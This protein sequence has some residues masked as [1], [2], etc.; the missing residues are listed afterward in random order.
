LLVYVQ[1]LNWQ[2]LELIGNH[3]PHNSLIWLHQL[4]YN[5]SDP[6]ASVTEGEAA[7]SLALYKPL[8]HSL[9]QIRL[10]QLLPGNKGDFIRCRLHPPRFLYEGGYEAL[11]YVWGNPMDEAKTILVDDTHLHITPNLEGALHCIRDRNNSRYLWIDAVCINQNDNHEKNHQVNL[12]SD[13]YSRAN[14][15]LVFL[16]SEDD[17]SEAFDYFDAVNKA[18]RNGTPLLSPKDVSKLLLVFWRLFTKPWW[19]RV[20]VI[21]EFV[22][23]S[24]DSLI[25]CGGR[26]TTTFAFIAGFVEL[27]KV[28]NLKNSLSVLDFQLQDVSLL[29]IMKM[30][31]SKYELLSGP[32]LRDRPELST[33]ITLSRF[34]DSTDQRDKIFALNSLM[35]EPFRTILDPDYSQSLRTVY[36]EITA[37]LLCIQRWGKFYKFFPVNADK[38][39]PSW[40]PD[41]SQHGSDTEAS[42]R[43]LQETPVSLT[44]G[45]DCWVLM[46]TLNIRGVEFD[47]IETTFEINEADVMNLPRIF[48]T[49]ESSMLQ[50]HQTEDH[51]TS[52]QDMVREL[53]RG[54]LLQLAAGGNM[55]IEEFLRRST[56]RSTC[57]LSLLSSL[58]KERPTSK[59][60][61][62]KLIDL[63]YGTDAD[64]EYQPE[65][66]ALAGDTAFQIQ[67]GEA[68]DQE[69][70]NYL[71]K[72]FSETTKVAMSQNELGEELYQLELLETN[73]RLKDENRQLKEQLRKYTGTEDHLQIEDY[74][75]R[76]APR[77]IKDFL[78][79]VLH[80]TV[81]ITKLGLLGMGDP[82]LKKGDK[83]TILFGIPMPMA[84]RCG[85]APF[86]HTMVGKARVNGIMNGE[87]MKFVDDGLLKEKIFHIR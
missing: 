34:H 9:P 80:C 50:E 45:I 85:S 41:Y 42:G 21:Q 13:I 23:A 47:T 73:R 64:E 87:L 14:R 16:G 29:S 1:L 57:C 72:N 55:I 20:W 75:L 86:Y 70:Q 10:L 78:S 61:P 11:S 82:G 2:I 22:L 68:Q 81:F 56:K 15:V 18:G 38:R 7:A 19:S 6:D 62:A 63:L 5:S 67:L 43:F 4:I 12:M 52:L 66:D 40:V 84:L 33:L 60:D 36:T 77:W 30:M 76:K 48:Y 44:R 27:Q 49:I 74:L 31:D 65:L 51:E 58:G 17:C 35:M 59:S 25:G 3:A 39:L 32:L 54:S 83:V 8:D 79:P 46:G 28:A 53:S 71:E 24:K 26:W 69:Q 37:L